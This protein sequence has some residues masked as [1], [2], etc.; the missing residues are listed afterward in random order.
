MPVTDV[1]KDADALTMTITSRFDAAPEQV[2]TVW[3]DPRRLER[4][5]GPPTYPA[6]VVDHDLT[7][8]GRVAYFMTSPEGDKY[9]GYWTITAVEP[10]HALSFVDGFADDAG[11][12]NPEMP[13]SPTQVRLAAD[14]AGTVMTIA[15]TFASAESMEKLL[16][17]GME[18]GITL[19]V[20]QI[21]AI[22]G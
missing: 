21:D 2:W 5:W 9:H 13:E 3:S 17:M 20:G 12:P 16:A 22:L 18:E 10:P 6:T 15:T 1:R 11:N 7:P 4:W 8:G 19:A 14:G